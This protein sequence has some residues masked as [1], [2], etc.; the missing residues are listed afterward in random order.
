MTNAQKLKMKKNLAK[1]R[2]A[3]ALKLKSKKRKPMAV[4]R[5]KPVKRAKSGKK[6]FV[7]GFTNEIYKPIQ[8]GRSYAL[9]TAD[10]KTVSKLPGVSKAKVKQAAADNKAIRGYVAKNGKTQYKLVDGNEFKAHANTIDDTHCNSVEEAFATHE[11]L[12][13]FIHKAGLT[14]KPEGLFMEELKW[15][16]LIRSAVRG[17]NIMMVGPTGCGKTLA[18]QSLVKGLA[19]PDYYF[20]LGATQ[21]PRATLIGNT[22][23]NKE[24]GTFFSESAFVK[25]IKTPNAIVLLDEISR[26]HPE[27]W[28]ILMTVLDY[29]QRYL[30]LDEAEGAPIVKVAPGVTFVATA[31]IGNEYT[32]TRVMDRAVR[33]RFVT[34]EMLPLDKEAEYKLLKFKFPQANDYALQ[35]LAEIAHTSREMVKSDSGKVTTTVSTR[36]NVEAAGLIYDG[37]TLL[38][39]AEI[40]ILPYFSADG[41]LDSERVFMRQLV[42]KYVKTTD[43][44][45]IN[46]IEADA[47]DL[48]TVKW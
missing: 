4:K 17:K 39:A 10:S 18:A 44:A 6:D 48:N 16:Y 38:E 30:R 3:R 46:D 15:K 7:V 21:D 9:L 41:G 2:K 20:N 33:D 32:S 8:V 24:T 12:K 25:A 11:Q 42:Q 29:N 26:A 27:A 45:L 14:L 40:S 36:V 31:N 28:N 19:R 35:S 34:I 43:D 1:A 47:D 22:H 13:E 37:F 23:F 5:L